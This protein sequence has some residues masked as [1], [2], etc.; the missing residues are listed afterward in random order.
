MSASDVLWGIKLSRVF[1]HKE[2]K[3]K[4]KGISA[5]LEMKDLTLLFGRSTL[6]S[7]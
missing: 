4:E 1:S 7:S 5:E 3:I 2:L 6:L